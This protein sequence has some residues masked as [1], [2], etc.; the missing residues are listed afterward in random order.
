[1]KRFKLFI[2]SAVLAGLVGIA[3]AAVKK[4]E[5]DPNHTILGFTAS[6][7][8]FDVQG[9]FDKYKVEVSGDPDTLADAKIRVEIDAKSIQTSN[10]TRDEH[11]RSGDFF[12]VGKHPKIVFTSTSVK[13]EGT[14]VVVDGNLEMHGVTKAMKVPFD[15]VSALNGAGVMETVYKADV[16]LNRKDFGIGT[17]SIGAKISLKDQVMLKLLLAGFF[18]EKKGK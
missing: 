6:T 14:R 2:G 4:F 17:E 13:K 9:R 15:A 1:M 3:Q 18:E 7:V 5:V 10:K 16:P 8:L 12:D 11:L